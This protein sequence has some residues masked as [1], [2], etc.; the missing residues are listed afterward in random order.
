MGLVVLPVEIYHREFDAKLLLASKLSSYYKH[1]VLIGWDRHINQLASKLPP[2][3]LLDKSCSSIIWKGRMKNY[4]SNGSTIIVNDEEGIT[5]LRDEDVCRVNRV[6]RT[7]ASLI[8][9]YI[10]WGKIEEKFFNFEYS[11]SYSYLD[12]K[13]DEFLSQLKFD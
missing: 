4:S 12:R 9:E 10:C 13:I 11:D 3:L 8:K 6:D 2:G 7:A 1:V 5:N